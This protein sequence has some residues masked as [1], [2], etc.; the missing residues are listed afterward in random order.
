MLPRSGASSNSL[1][2]YEGALAGGASSLLQETV[3]LKKLKEYI[4]PSEC[5]EVSR[6][7]HPGILSAD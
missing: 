6:V 2:E 4:A 5:S 1:K 3:F 7:D